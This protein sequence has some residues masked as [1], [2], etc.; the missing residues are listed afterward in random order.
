MVIIDSRSDGDESSEPKN[1]LHGENII[2]EHVPCLR[3]V[4]FLFF[5]DSITAVSVYWSVY[6]P[7]KL[8]I[9]FVG[10]SGSS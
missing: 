2:L 5:P 4:V 1:G 10:N 7:H 6:L 8:F 9:N 3:V